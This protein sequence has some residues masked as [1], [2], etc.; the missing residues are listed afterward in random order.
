MENGR[1]ILTPL[2][3]TFRQDGLDGSH[4]NDSGE[5]LDAHQ[6]VKLGFRFKLTY[7]VSYRRLMRFLGLATEECPMCRRFAYRNG[8]MF[9]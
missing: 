5:D 1:T 2:G 8:I 6:I 7:S 3:A 9:R 4:R